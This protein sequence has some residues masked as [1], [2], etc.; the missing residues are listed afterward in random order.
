MWKLRKSKSVFSSYLGRNR[1]SIWVNR[2]N[3]I[4]QSWLLWLNGSKRAEP[5]TRVIMERKPA[6]SQPLSF[7]GRR[8]HSFS[9][10]SSWFI[11]VLYCKTCMHQWLLCRAENKWHEEIHKKIASSLQEGESNEM[12]ASYFKGVTKS[13]YQGMSQQFQLYF[14]I[15][16]WSLWSNSEGAKHFPCLV[17]HEIL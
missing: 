2:T 1:A 11:E 5:E 6:S 14:S 3:M 15:A 7:S 16:G 10:T 9:Y 13:K 17:F 4:C 8:W 12:Q